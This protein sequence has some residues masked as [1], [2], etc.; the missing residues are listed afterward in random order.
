MP[1]TGAQ[2]LNDKPAPTPTNGNSYRRQPPPSI[3][4]SNRKYSADTVQARALQQLS[5]EVAASLR[6]DLVSARSSKARKEVS[7]ALRQAIAAWD[8]C[9]NR[10]RIARGKPLPGS[11]RPEAPKPKV[12]KQKSGAHWSEQPETGTDQE[13]LSG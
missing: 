13:K 1:N 12:P 9:A 3:G 11:M 5:Y 2:E 8:V 7:V 4:A 10:A 6:Q